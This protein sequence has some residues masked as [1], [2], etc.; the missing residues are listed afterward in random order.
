MKGLCFFIWK[1]IRFNRMA[2]ILIP[3]PLE[4]NPGFYFSKWVFGWGSIEIW[5]TWGSINLFTE[6]RSSFSKSILLFIIFS[7]FLLVK[8]VLTIQKMYYMSFNNR[9]IILFL[10]SW[11]NVIANSKSEWLKE[12]FRLWWGS[13]FYS[14]WGSII[15][16]S[17]FDW[18]CI[19]FFKGWGCIQ[20]WGCIQADTVCK[21]YFTKEIYTFKHR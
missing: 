14:S 7:Y 20:E 16:K 3:Y 4:Y 19:S 9:K 10:L 8:S 5:S 6:V 11:F 21:V 18:G 2:R 13:I 12:I 15:S 1:N 17:I